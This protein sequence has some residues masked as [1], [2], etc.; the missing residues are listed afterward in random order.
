MTTKEKKKSAPPD[1][2]LADLCREADLRIQCLVSAK[3]DL[4]AQQEKRSAAIAAAAAPFDP[5]IKE[6]EGDVLKGEATLRQL[7]LDYR[8]QF[9]PG[10]ADQVDL[11]HGVL[12]LQITKPLRRA[13]DVVERLWFSGLA[14]LL[15]VDVKADW[16]GL[17]KLPA[18]Q[19]AALG[20]ERREKTDI[21]WESKPTG[22][23]KR[24][25]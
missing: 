6:L 19:L 20:L 16:D 9:F 2:P 24:S 17:D 13:Q 10:T 1:R 11:A 14:H 5:G 4:A 21:A 3:A 12:L 7:A 22:D 15:K 23:N 25:K 18:E 8:Q